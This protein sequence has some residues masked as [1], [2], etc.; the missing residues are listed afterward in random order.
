MHV[1]IDL[2]L[3]RLIISYHIISYDVDPVVQ[4]PWGNNDNSPQRFEETDREPAVRT[5][6]SKPLNGQGLSMGPV[7][8]LDLLDLLLRRLIISYHVDVV[9]QLPWENNDNS[10]VI[11]KRLGFVLQS[12]MVLASERIYVRAVWLPAGSRRFS[13]GFQ[14]G[15]LKHFWH[16]TQKLLQVVSRRQF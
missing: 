5:R 16:Q 12:S 6:E 8:W 9:V 13:E 15:I 1:C 11:G 3:R 10:Q 4:L 7:I 14:E 2:L